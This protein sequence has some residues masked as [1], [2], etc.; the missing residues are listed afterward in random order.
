MI[1]DLGIYTR[2]YD[3]KQVQM[4][5]TVAPDYQ[6][7]GYGEEAIEGALD[8][9]FKELGVEQ[10][11]AIIDIRNHGAV[12]LLERLDFRKHGDFTTNEEIDGEDI[13]EHLFSLSKKQWRKKEVG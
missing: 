10:V 7:E 12:K 1:G 4:F 6:Q 9:V 11:I 5:V 13:T 3:D 2:D 8:F